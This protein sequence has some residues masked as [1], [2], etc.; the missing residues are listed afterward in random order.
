MRKETVDKLKRFALFSKAEGPSSLD[1]EKRELTAVVSTDDVD[2]D[3]EIVEPSA[4]EDKIDTF[5]ANP[6]FLWMHEA[7]KP[8]IGR[9]LDLRI[10]KHS[11][12]A[13]L[14]FRPEGESELADDIFTLYSD[15]TL[16]MFS[17]GFR[18]FEMVFSEN[19]E[20]GESKPPRIT[21]GELLEVSAVSI[22]ANPNVGAKAARLK[23]LAFQERRPAPEKVIEKIIYSPVTREQAIEQ[24]IEEINTTRRRML[25][26]ETVSDEAMGWIR[27]MQL[28]LAGLDIQE[29]GDLQELYDKLLGVQGTLSAMAAG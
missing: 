22:P 7:R 29:D 3:G 27:K 14:K 12:E 26:G 11:I 25:R 18:V 17:I 28:A 15:G 1:V 16:R 19:E 13:D 9:A 6:V 24:A 8:P 5:M 21:S 10:E 23:S 4:F 2:R 20:T